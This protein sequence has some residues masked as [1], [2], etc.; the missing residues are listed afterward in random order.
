[1]AKQTIL[2]TDTVKD[3]LLTKVNQNFDEV[4]EELDQKAAKDHTHGTGGVVLSLIDNE[5]SLGEG[6]TEGELKYC[7]ENKRWYAWNSTSSKWLLVS[8]PELSYFYT[9]NFGG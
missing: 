8:R 2:G 9:I 5:G 4:Y 6:A 7:Y 1:M 3:A